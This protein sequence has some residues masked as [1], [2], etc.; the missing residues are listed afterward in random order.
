MGGRWEAGSKR[1]GYMYTYGW[2]MLMFDRKQQNSVKKLSFNKKWIKK[3]NR[4]SR[5]LL[6]LIVSDSKNDF[7]PR[8][9][10]LKNH[11]QSSDLF[12]TNNKILKCVL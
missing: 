10:K 11:E 12:S 2:F 7:C 4:Q 1:R 8:I 6:L 3:N 9:K 5:Y